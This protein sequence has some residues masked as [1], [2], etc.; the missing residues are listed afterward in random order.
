MSAI[1]FLCEGDLFLAN[2]YLL[3]HTPEESCYYG[4]FVHGHSDD[5]VFDVGDDGY[6]TRVG[7]VGDDA[8]NMVGIAFLK[9]DDA[10]I[11][12]RKI[13]ETYGTSGYEDLFWDDVVGH[14]LDVLKL[15]V[16]PVGPNDIFEID[17]VRE[18]EEI[19]GR[20]L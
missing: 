3:I 13:A 9:S 14:H 7:K 11:L 4:K 15:R 6:I 2:R 5:W 18:L 19:N 16:R 8:Y 1:F 10:K 17:T 12:S 20:K